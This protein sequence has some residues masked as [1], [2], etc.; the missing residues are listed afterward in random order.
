MRDHIVTKGLELTTS[1]QTVLKVSTAQ[2]DQIHV[3][4]ISLCN[5]TGAARTA[6]VNLVKV[7]TGAGTFSIA[8]GIAIPANSRVQINN[9]GMALLQLGYSGT[10]QDCLEAL[11]DANSAIDIVVSYEKHGVIKVT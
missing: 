2:R 7:G 4:M 6:T 1:A 8:S 10:S 11:A 3:I 9:D 5:K